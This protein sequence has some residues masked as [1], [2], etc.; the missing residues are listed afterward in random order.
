M[1]GLAEPEAGQNF[2]GAR[3]KGPVDVVIV[4]GF[5]DELLAACGDR[6]N[7]FLADRCAFLRQVAEV[8]AAFPFDGTLVGLF[9]T[10]NEV[11]KSLFARAVGPD[12]AEAIRA[13]DEKRHLGEEL[14]G[15][16]GLGN[17]G[18]GQHGTGE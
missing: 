14:A 10:E 11:E 13:R 5:G 4:V 9:L 1:V 18:Q 7:R 3:L 17:V 2:L 6:E 8:G 16:V 12:Q 15:T